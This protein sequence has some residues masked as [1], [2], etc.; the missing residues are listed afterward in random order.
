[1]QTMNMLLSKILLMNSVFRSELSNASTAGT[2]SAALT[3]VRTTGSCKCVHI[4]KPFKFLY[5]FN[6]PFEVF[7][8]IQKKMKTST[9]TLNMQFWHDEPYLAGSNLC[10]L[11]FYGFRHLRTEH[12]SGC[13]N[14][15][16]QN[17][18]CYNVIFHLLKLYTTKE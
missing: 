4:H 3:R 13:N 18:M 1:M 2:E 17:L 7:V 11:F 16:C 10:I 12:L 5:S 15:V 14:S 9:I 6:V 8:S